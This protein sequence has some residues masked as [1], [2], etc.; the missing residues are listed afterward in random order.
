MYLYKGAGPGTHWW[1]NDAQTAG[2]FVVGHAPRNVSAIIRHV[3]SYSWPSPYSSFSAS[4]AAAAAYALS[5]PRGKATAEQPGWVYEIDVALA[6]QLGV[7]FL[8]PARE[9]L[10]QNP[11]IGSPGV[12]PTLHNGGQDL[13]LGVADPVLHRRVLVT[14]P[15]Q[16]GPARHVRGAGP[17]IVHDELRAVIFAL[18]DAEILA[19]NPVP[20]ACITARYPVD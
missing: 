17:P 6:Q 4:F 9:I 13:V 7:H 11:A 15:R 19:T 5:G 16:P 3:V 10:A 1:A 8:D 12:I 2:G 14:P 20:E 18:R